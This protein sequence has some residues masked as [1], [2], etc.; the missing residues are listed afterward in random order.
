MITT[1]GWGGG[2]ITTFGWGGPVVFLVL[3]ADYAIVPRYRQVGVLLCIR[4]I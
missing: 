4:G 2:A 1:R 3:V